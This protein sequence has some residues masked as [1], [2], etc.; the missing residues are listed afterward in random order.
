M[1]IQHAQQKIAS[2]NPHNYYQVYN[3]YEI[4]YWGKV[5]EWIKRYGKKGMRTLDIGCAFGVL[6]YFC[7]Q[8]GE[9]KAMDSNSSWWTR[10]LDI[11]YKVSNIETE[12]IPF[13][14]KF[15]IIILTEVLEHFKYNP[16]PTLKKIKKSLKGRLFIS[17]PD[18]EVG[19]GHRGT[20]YSDLPDPVNKHIETEYP[21]ENLHIYHYSTNEIK[22]LL[23]KCG[24]KI[25]SLESSSAPWGNHLNIEAQ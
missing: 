6:S 18:A 15:D 24:Y 22:Q 21:T 20:T 4:S 23:D 19:W 13:S 11:E 8:F 17:T 9:V 16:E 10:K 14:G 3:N 7:T 5:P 2:L 25:I 12:P 1:T